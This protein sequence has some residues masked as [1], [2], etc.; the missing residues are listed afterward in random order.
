MTLGERIRKAREEATIGVPALAEG[1]GVHRR[2]VE[3]WE[4][5]E[6]VPSRAK[7]RLLGLLL[8]K[9]AAWFYGGC[10]CGSEDWVFIDPYGERYPEG[11]ALCGACGRTEG[12]TK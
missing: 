12:A 8:Q 3:R 11:K 2:T 10:L 5:D 6:V 4:S 9:P 7:V 1:L